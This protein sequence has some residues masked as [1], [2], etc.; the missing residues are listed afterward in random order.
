M[1]VLAASF[2]WGTASAQKHH[3]ANEPDT[4]QVNS[5]QEVFKKGSMHGHVRN[6]FMATWNH[7]ELSDNYANAIGAEIAYKTAFFHGFRV[8]FAGLFTYNLF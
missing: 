5:V 4:V 1:A 8:G 6:Y 2:G 7:R 3:E